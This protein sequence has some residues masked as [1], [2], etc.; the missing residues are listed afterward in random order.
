M[1]LPITRERPA[2]RHRTPLGDTTS[3]AA[4]GH[5]T[6]HTED[7]SQFYSGEQIPHHESLRP[8]G[9][10]QSPDAIKGRPPTNPRLSAVVSEDQNDSNRNSQ[11]STTSTNASGKS[12]RKTHIGP[13]RLGKTLGRG[14]C[15][16]VRLAKHEL[17]GQMAAIKIVS[18]SSATLIR[19]ASLANDKM[20][21]AADDDEDE[22]RKL[23]FGIERE[24]V[25]MKL[26]EHPNVIK[27]Y[28]VWENRKEL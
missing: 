9:Q 28:D 6:Y 2:I 8:G 5:P 21:A 15:G 13:W 26:I 10:L 4:N 20:R 7:T 25:I 11:I 22:T 24:V 14:S 19:S 27:L 3:Q 18:K 1:E 23:P 12:R 17:T 16:R